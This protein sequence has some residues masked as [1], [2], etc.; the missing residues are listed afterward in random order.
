MAEE[1]TPPPESD[2]MAAIKAEWDLE[3]QIRKTEMIRCST[4]QASLKTRLAG[5]LRAEADKINPPS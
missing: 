3:A 2:A 5:Q 1:F 4:A